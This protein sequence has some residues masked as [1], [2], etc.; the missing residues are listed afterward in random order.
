MTAW[1]NTLL[2]Y[3]RSGH[4]FLLERLGHQ[5]GGQESGPVPTPQ[6]FGSQLGR[7]ASCLESQIAT[8]GAIDQDT[9]VMDSSN[10]QPGDMI[11]QGR[12]RLLEVRRDMILDKLKNNLQDN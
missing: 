9:G 8:S 1:E 3:M 12:R 2:I 10:A 7:Q 5:K 4:G 6:D 11:R